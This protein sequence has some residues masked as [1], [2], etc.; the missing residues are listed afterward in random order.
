MRDPSERST[1]SRLCIATIDDGTLLAR[2]VVDEHGCVPFWLPPSYVTVAKLTC[3]DAP[4]DVQLSERQMRV[5]ASTVPSPC[6]AIA[7][8]AHGFFLAGDAAWRT[9]CRP[10][11]PCDAAGGTA[12]LLGDSVGMRQGQHWVENFFSSA[13]SNCSLGLQQGFKHISRGT[14]KLAAGEATVDGIKSHESSVLGA[15]V[16]VCSRPSSQATFVF[17]PACIL[18]SHFVRNA[19]VYARECA[20][21]LTGRYSAGAIEAPTARLTAELLGRR[22]TY[23]WTLVT[24]GHHQV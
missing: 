9:A 8:F 19:S 17:E 23:N 16:V 15:G 18:E 21:R 13:G 5:H 3:H 14:V 2:E 6:K 1:A 24:I 20:E 4:M 12:R 11:V 10:I 7:G 22:P